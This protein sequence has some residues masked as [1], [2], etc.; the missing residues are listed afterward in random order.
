MKALGWKEIAGRIDAALLKATSSRSDLVVLSEEAIR[1][2]YRSLCVPPYLVEVAAKLTEGTN[3]RVGTVIGFTLGLNAMSA[4]I[5]EIKT[6]AQMGAREVD[7]VVGLG[8]YLSDGVEFVE[9]ESSTLVG[10]AKDVGI[11][12]VKSIIEVGYLT[13]DQVRE[14]CVGCSSGGVDF[15]KT[16]TGYGPRPTAAEDVRLMV[17]AV[18]GKT[19]VKAAGGIKNLKDAMTMFE[20]GAELVGT[21]NARAIVEQARSIEG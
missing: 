16:S 19:P 15:L 14:V 3:V 5:F 7:Y 6:A 13:K 10:E 8:G 11:D 9:V 18:A 17:E 1:L 20:A 2:G 12:T 21:S 4:K